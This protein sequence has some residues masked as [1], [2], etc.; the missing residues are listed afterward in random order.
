MGT[1]TSRRR[2]DGTLRYRAPV[3]VERR[4]EA[5]YSESRTFGK[6]AV[7]KDRIRQRE[8]E[9]EVPGALERVMHGGLSVGELIDR[10]RQEVGAMAPFGR[11]K[12]THLG[13]LMKRDIVELDALTLKASAIVKHVRDRRCRWIR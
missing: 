3:R 5:V 6:K 7:A 12:G 1:I 8:E 13:L 4:G 9:P 11:T 10:Y 2:K